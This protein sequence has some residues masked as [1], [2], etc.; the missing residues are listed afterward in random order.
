MPQRKQWMKLAPLAIAT[1]GAL[2]SA[3]AFAQAD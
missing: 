1:L 2:G 3:S